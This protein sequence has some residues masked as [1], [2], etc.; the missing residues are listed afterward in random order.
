MKLLKNLGLILLAIWLVIRGLF[1]LIDAS[2][3]GL[4][5]VL[6]ILAIAAGFLILFGLR[7]T[8][9]SNPRSLGDLLLGIWL[10]LSALL[11]LLNASFAGAGRVLDI[12]AIAAGALILYAV[13]RK[14]PLGNLGRLLLSG[15]LILMGLLS[16][17]SLS[18]AGSGTV[19]AVLALA[20][21][22]LLLVG[23]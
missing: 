18:F 4:G 2:F 9:L 17:L 1:S 3:P 13:T 19:L 22:I 20:A 15:W 21:G 11:S 8:T 16:L 12:L 23:R 14:N 10:L 5:L 7:S 6:D